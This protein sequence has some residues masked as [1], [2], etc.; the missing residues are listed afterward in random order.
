MILKLL[1]QLPTS[2]FSILFCLHLQIYGSLTSATTAMAANLGVCP[3]STF[4][5]V[6]MVAIGIAISFHANIV[7]YRFTAA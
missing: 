3:I 6:L 4:Y 1:P 7:D 2:S 5:A